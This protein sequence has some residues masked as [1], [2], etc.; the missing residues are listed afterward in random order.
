MKIIL[1]NLGDEKNL[2]IGGDEGDPALLVD[3]QKHLTAKWPDIKTKVMD[4]DNEKGSLLETKI[5]ELLRE[6]LDRSEQDSEP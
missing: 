1:I 4:L 6:A 3:F 2:M 5:N